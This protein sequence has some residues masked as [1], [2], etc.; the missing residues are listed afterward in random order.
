[1][2]GWTVTWTSLS[3]LSQLRLQISSSGLETR[4]VKSYLE[5]QPKLLNH[6]SS[7]LLQPQQIIDRL[8][9]KI[10]FY[11]NNVVLL[12]HM[13]L[14]TEFAIKHYKMLS[15]PPNDPFSI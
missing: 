13:K 5:H 3:V 9:Y 6:E 2:L 11:R 7:F 14:V 4:V 1:V 15:L 10:I 8:I 12:M